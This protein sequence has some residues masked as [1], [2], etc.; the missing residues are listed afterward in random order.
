MD[1]LVI[2]VV[3][4]GKIKW[5]RKYIIFGLVDLNKNP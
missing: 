1:F 2:F 5:I 3:K 4:N